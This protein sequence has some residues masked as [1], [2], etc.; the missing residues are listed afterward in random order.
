MWRE[1]KGR[2]AAQS[3]HSQS[4][5][6]EGIKSTTE[7]LV[8]MWPVRLDFYF[9]RGI[10]DGKTEGTECVVMISVRYPATI[11]AFMTEKV[12]DV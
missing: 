12:P 4:P 11:P 10:S 1:E 2:T 3:R 6:G 7:D 8:Q 5:Q 9:L